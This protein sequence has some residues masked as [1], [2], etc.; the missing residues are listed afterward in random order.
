M[1]PGERGYPVQWVVP[2]EG[3]IS[4]AVGGTW[5]SFLPSR[6][7]IGSIPTSLPLTPISIPIPHPHPPSPILH[8]SPHPARII[9]PLRFADPIPHRI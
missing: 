7:R 1:V 2:G 6:H 3:G 8:A 4:D 5:R 9:S